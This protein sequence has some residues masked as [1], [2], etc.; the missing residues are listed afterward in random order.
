MYNIIEKYVNKLSINDI[1][2]FLTSKMINLSESELEF[3]YS[4]IKKNWASVVS[5]PQ[6]LNFD[7]FNNKFSSNNLMKLKKLFNEYLT[8]YQQFL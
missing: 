3:A 1:N 7:R 5:N 8:K 6:L 2:T 4:F